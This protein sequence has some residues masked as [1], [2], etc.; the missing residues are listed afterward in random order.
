MLWACVSFSALNLDRGNLSQANTDNILGDLGMNTDDY[1]LG[2]TLFR[3]CFLSAELPSQLVSKKVPQNCSLPDRHLLTL[4]QLG[5]DRWIPIQM[6]GWCTYISSLVE[7]AST[8]LC[9]SSAI[10]TMAQFF[11]TGRTSFLICRGLLGFMQ[12]GFIPDLILYLSC[13][14]WASVPLSRLP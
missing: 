1:N 11:L 8:N 13:A 4:H 2:N 9:D 10:V 5:P 7:V 3:V 6:C 12:G 14:F